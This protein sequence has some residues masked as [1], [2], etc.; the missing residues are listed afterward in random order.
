MS[1]VRPVIAVVGMGSES[2]AAAQSL[3]SDHRR[4]LEV[5]PHEVSSVTPT[6]WVCTSTD[7]LRA[8]VMSEPNVPVVITDTVVPTGV[9]PEQ[10]SDLLRAWNTDTVPA[11]SLPFHR[12][13]TRGR[14]CPMLREVVISTDAVAQISEFTVVHEDRVLQEVRADGIVV[15]G[16]SGAGGYAQS[17]G[18]P[19]LGAVDGLLTVP[20]AGFTSHTPMWVTP[21]P[22]TVTV[23]RKEAVV[24]ACIDGTETVQ[25][26]PGASLSV[27]QV[28]RYD[29]IGQW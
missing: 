6:V 14:E 18:G 26:E 10:L 7:G 11:R 12:V 3:E 21:P 15:A 5:P 29:V 8:V 27:T 22:V 13:H 20:M 24:S 19:R 28:G 4:I 23:V 9:P 1:R 17:L 2:A 16:P 25:L